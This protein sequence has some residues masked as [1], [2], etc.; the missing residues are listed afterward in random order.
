MGANLKPE[1]FF[2]EQEQLVNSGMK[3]IVSKMS[4]KSSKILTDKQL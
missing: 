2:K 4:T 1:G 3:G